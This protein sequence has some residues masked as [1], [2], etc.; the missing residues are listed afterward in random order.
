MTDDVNQNEND[1][2]DDGDGNKPYV[3][4]QPKVVFDEKIRKRT[5]AYQHVFPTCRRGQSLTQASMS[6]QY[7]LH[8]YLER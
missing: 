2:F 8:V 7:L 6:K 3:P 1:L 4:Q 5:V